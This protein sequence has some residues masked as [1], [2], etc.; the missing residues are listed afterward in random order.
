MRREPCER[1]YIGD[2]VRYKDVRTQSLLR[3]TLVLALAAWAMFVLSGWAMTGSEPTVAHAP[4]L[5]SSALSAEFAEV[6]EHPH[7]KDESAVTEL[8]LITAARPLRVTAALVAV[9]LAMAV[10]VAAGSSLSNTAPTV[11]GP[12]AHVAFGSAG[13]RL[14]TILCVSRR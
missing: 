5:L 14:L 7:L 9:G 8:D 13:R 12:P 1:C 6:V 10:L 4:H 11:R 3:R 2:I